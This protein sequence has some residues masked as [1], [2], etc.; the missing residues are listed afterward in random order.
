MGHMTFEFGIRNI[1]KVADYN[2]YYLI[3]LVLFLL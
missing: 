1:S 2:I 3:I